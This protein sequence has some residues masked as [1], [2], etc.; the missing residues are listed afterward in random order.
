MANK[1]RSWQELGLSWHLLHAVECIE[2][3]LYMSY[4]RNSLLAEEYA[5]WVILHS[6]SQFHGADHLD[7]CWLEEGNLKLDPQLTGLLS[8]QAVEQTPY[9]GV[10]G[11]SKVVIHNLS[12]RGL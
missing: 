5:S 6:L 7:H 10:G 11:D 8:W 2:N 1:N 12:T 9:M 3:T 4:L